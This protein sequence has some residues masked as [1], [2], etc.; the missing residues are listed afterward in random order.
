MQVQLAAP[1]AAEYNSN[2][3]WT[4][5]LGPQQPGGP[6]NLNV[7]VSFRGS[8][9]TIPVTD[10][11]FGDV[12]L[13]SGQ[14]NMAFGLPGTFNSTEE[15]SAVGNYPN[16]R[17]FAL[18]SFEAGSELVDAPKNEIGLPWASA[19]TPGALCGARR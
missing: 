12:W 15:C 13:A 18:N 17:L 1:V 6:F 8:V 14:S 3:S 9:Q 5:C 4:A 11:L 10:V 19:A 16:V 7:Q 2:S